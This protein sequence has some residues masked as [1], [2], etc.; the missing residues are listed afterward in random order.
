M[1]ITK[2]LCSDIRQRAMLKML[3]D[4]IRASDVEASSSSNFIQA[5][6]PLIKA[7]FVERDGLNS[8]SLTGPGRILALQLREM[9]DAVE[10]LQDAFWRTHRLD[11]I[12]DHLL[13]TIGALKGGGVVAPNSHVTRAQVSFID[14][15]THAKK[16][17]GASSIYV[18]G[19]PEMIS[20]ALDN[21]AEVELILTQS[22]IMQID[23]DV[24][25]SWVGHGPKFKIHIREVKAA[26]AVA[27]GV[28]F[29]GMF[30]HA[31]VIDLLQEWV[32]ES[33]RAAE[34]GRELFEYYLEG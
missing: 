1:V 3:G 33:E 8:Y 32:C 9:I 7:G 22:V 18:E 28:L 6:R 25:N 20:A 10:V 31:G 17:F 12:P 24:F 16:I 11:Y 27:D 23:R 21:G 14:H 5:I 15:V 26:F 4:H 19:Y 13:Y 30:D 2:L 29:L 34:W